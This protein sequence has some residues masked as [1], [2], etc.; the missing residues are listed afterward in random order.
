MWVVPLRFAPLRFAPLRFA[1]LRFAPLRFVVEVR[2][3]EVRSGS[4]SGL[5]AEH[6]SMHCRNGFGGDR[7][8]PVELVL[9]RQQRRND[10]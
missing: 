1:R 4:M 2:L 7:Q 5:R 8:W 3:E 9:C 6:Q 10:R